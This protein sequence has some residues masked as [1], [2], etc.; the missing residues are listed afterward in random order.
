MRDAQL[1]PVRLI[2]LAL[3]LLCATLFAAPVAA[4]EAADGERTLVVVG[5]GGAGL[6]LRSGPGTN[7]QKLTVLPEGTSV[8]VLNGPISDGQS[9]WYHV[10]LKGAGTMSGYSSADYLSAAPLSSTTNA[11]PALRNVDTSPAPAEAGLAPEGSR[12]V[13]AKVTGYAFGADGGAVGDTTASGTKTH[14]GTVAA[15]TRYYPFGTKLMIEGFGD[16]VFT[17]E[18]TGGGVKGDFFDV[19]YPDLA[20]AAAFG[21]QYRQVTILPPGS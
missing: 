16:M 8:L 18:D 4:Q 20:T 13:R 1:P 10:Q 2:A 21:L 14:W 15:D 5:T 19:W 12:V 11:E 3:L 6:F 17:V 9:N 7:N